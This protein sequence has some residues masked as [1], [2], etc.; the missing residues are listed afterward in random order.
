M[1]HL[2]VYGTLVAATLV[3]LLGRQMVQKI[4][5]LTKYT[6][7]E[8]VA[9]G[10]LV[11]LGFLLLK[12]TMGF[13][14]SFDMSLKDPLMLAFFATIGLNANLA[15]LRKG[16]KALSIFIFVVVGLLLV[17]NA[18]GIGM[19]KMLGLDPLMGLLAGSITL[20]GGHGTGAA[21]SKVFS[22]RYGFE[23]AT[24]VAMA[25]ATF[26]LVLGGLIGGPVA[27]YLVKHSSTPNGT[28]DDT[29]VPTAFEKPYSGRMITSLVLIETLAMIAICLTAGHFIA[30][31]LRGTSFELPTF[32][33]VLFVGV[34]LSN[35]MHAIGFYRVFERAVSVLGNVSL[36]LFLA[37]ALMSLKLW[38]LASL[39]LPML[40]ILLAQTLVM[41]LYAIFVTYRVMGKNYDAA[42]LAAGHCGFG[43]GATPTAIAN[44]QAITDRFGPSHLAFLVVPMVGAFFIDI[45]NAIVIKLYLML[46]V[47]P[48]VMG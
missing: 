44:M 8:P 30:D 48:A 5:F 40:A 10:L 6:I 21:W 9:G 39:A 27:R 38:E 14:V 43:L 22:E 47:F 34:V 46:P 35:T 4:P 28:P 20:S 15:S 32:V 1:I 11:A 37:M 26:G 16:G 23:N 24:E 42:V 17:Q 31:F 25:C 7:P 45:V 13:E 29:E 41:A 12:Q 18:I 2:D 3:L 36:S 19:A 33:C